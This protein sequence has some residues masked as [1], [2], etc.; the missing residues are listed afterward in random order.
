[1]IEINGV[2]YKVKSSIKFGILRRVM[3]E[4]DN[5]SN[6]I[7]F[8]QNILSPSPTNDE[9]DE[10]MDDDIMAITEIYHKLQTE[11]S[12]ETKKKLSY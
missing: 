6:Q 10:F 12:I 2:N 1:M 7:E 4:P 3:E 11:K 8:I 5:I 9:I